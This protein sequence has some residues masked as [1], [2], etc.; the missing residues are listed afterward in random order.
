MRNVKIN[1]RT[2]EEIKKGLACCAS[3]NAIC[4]SCPFVTSG[5]ACIIRKSEDAL[6]YIQQLENQI[7]ELTEKVAQLEEAQPKWNE[8]KD[9][10]PDDELKKYLVAFPS[11]GSYVIDIGFYNGE[12]GFMLSH[13]IESDITHWMPLPEPP[14]YDGHN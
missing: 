6:A 1:G 11:S 12:F 8:I 5:A 7:G 9:R 14:K 2:S 13:W 10:P 3:E 4:K